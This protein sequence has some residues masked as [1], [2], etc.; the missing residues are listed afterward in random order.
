MVTIYS[1]VAEEENTSNDSHLYSTVDSNYGISRV[2]GL[3]SSLRNS[4]RFTSRNEKRIDRNL[5]TEEFGFNYFEHAFREN[6]NQPHF[7]TT[8]G[9]VYQVSPEYENIHKERGVQDVKVSSIPNW[10]DFDLAE[11]GNAFEHSNYSTSDR[12]SFFINE[13]GGRKKHARSVDGFER[14]NAIVSHVFESRASM[15]QVI[16]PITPNHPKS[17]KEYQ[18]LMAMN[19]HM[20]NGMNHFISENMNF[21]NSS[22][23]HLEIQQPRVKSY[24]S[25][26]NTANL[27]YAN[28]RSKFNSV[29][30]LS[31]SSFEQ[32]PASLHQEHHYVL[33]NHQHHNNF[34]PDFEV[35]HF[36]DHK[37]E[38]VHESAHDHMHKVEHFRS[39][40]ND[41]E[42]S[43]SDL[44]STSLS[45]EELRNSIIE[46]F[47]FNTAEEHTNNDV[48]LNVHGCG[49][50]YA[51][52]S[53]MNP[54]GTKKSVLQ[55]IL[56]DKPLMEAISKKQKRGAY[57][58]AHCPEMF[59]TIFEFAKHIDEYQVERKYKCPFPLCPWKILG[60]P[61]LQEL[62]RHCL[63]QHIDELTPEQQYLI[64]GKSGAVSEVYHCESPYCDKAFHRKDSYRRH[65]KMVHKNPKSRFNIRLVK[66]MKSCPEYLNKDLVAKERFLVEK[67]NSRRR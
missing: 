36:H 51:E 52:A 50:H 29:P 33:Q 53:T 6:V 11:N 16:T 39:C 28:A 38:E 17:S 21:N 65:V 7:S 13:K 15:P 63:N 41:H 60:L 31:L 3:E 42:P 59:N 56:D 44:D 34:I 14:D 61:K 20:N 4:D 67:M 1:P 66:A 32:T 40:S 8:R 55:Q 25:Y 9:S 27:A 54:D 5:N 48:I 43:S 19:M 35:D 23:E 24:R 37:H 22:M 18:S 46:K 30:N 49:S 62:K 26:Q 47:T 45:Y 12:N 57:K 58:C 2:L 64:H 10:Y